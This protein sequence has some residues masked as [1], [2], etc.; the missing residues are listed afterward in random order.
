MSIISIIILL[1]CM[2]IAFIC[3]CIV[4]IQALITDGLSL[5][6]NIAGVDNLMQFWEPYTPIIAVLGTTATIFISIHHIMRYIDIEAARSLSDLRTQLN[7]CSNKSVHKAL[8]ETEDSDNNKTILQSTS[9][10]D[11]FNYLGC[12]ELGA[13]MLE[14]KHITFEEFFNQFGYRVQ[15]IWNNHKVREHIH[16]EKEYY[17]ALIYVFNEMRKHDKI[18]D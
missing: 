2:I 15:N 9:N 7:Q 6:L 14:R 5:Q 18:H 17:K 13:I 3:V 12:I 4:V 10:T 8:L 1:L 11:L 16:S